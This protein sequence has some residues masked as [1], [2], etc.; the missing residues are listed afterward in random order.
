[1]LNGIVALFMQTE[2]AGARRRGGLAVEQWQHAQMTYLLHVAAQGRHPRLAETL[3]QAPTPAEED[4]FD[5]IVSRT[6][7]GFL[8]TPTRRG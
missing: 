8:G 1:M 7:T 6:M 5:L 4:P 2:L 3:T